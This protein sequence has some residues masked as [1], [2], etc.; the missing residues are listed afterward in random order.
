MGEFLIAAVAIV[1]VFIALPGIIFGF[2]YKTKKDKQDLLKMEYERKM[3][4]LEIEKENLHI[5]L[6]EEENKKYDR[7]IDGD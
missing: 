6:L 2:I 1:S 5:K 7:I 4:E 3:L